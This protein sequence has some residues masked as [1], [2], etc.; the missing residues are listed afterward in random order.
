MYKTHSCGELTKQHIGLDVTLAGWVH[1]RRDHGGLIFL[2][3][4][5]RDGLTQVVC[6]SS[7]NSDAHANASRARNEFVLQVR[8]RVRERPEGLANP[9]LATGDIEVLAESVE[10]L[11]E[12]KTPPFYINE[13][14]DVEETLRLKYRYLDLRRERMQRNMILRHRVVKFIRDYLDA[15]GFIEIETPI[16]IKS[17]PE[18]AR[19]YLVPS[20]LHPGKF[21]AL[22]QSPQQLKQLLMVAGMER[23]F[24]IARCFRDEDQRADRQPEFT[25]LDLEMSFVDQEDILS[26]IEGLFIALIEAMR[27]PRCEGGMD[28]R[29]RILQT[30]FPRLTYAEAMER[31]GSDKPDLRFGMQL[32]DLSD[33]VAESAF[34]VFREAVLHG[35]QV[36]GILAPGAGAYTRKQLDEL[37]EMVKR[38]GAKGLIWIIPERDAVRSPAAKHLTPAETS[39]II[40]RMG[41]NEGDLILTIADKPEIVAEALGNLR[42]EMGRRLGLLDDDVL[43]FAWVLDFPLLEWSAEEGRWTAKHHPFTSAKDEDWPLLESE[44]AKVRA[45]AYDIVANGYEVGGGSIRIHRRDL[46]NRMFRALGITEEEMQAQFGHLLEAFEYG[47]PPHGGIAP[48][49][50][51]LVMLLAGEPNIREVIAFPKTQAAVDLMTSAPSPVS[52]RQL[53]DLHLKLALDGK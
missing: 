43:A 29:K 38:W 53:R 3:L 27:R 39:A 26:L 42:L 14:T 16:L 45:K 25:Q 21:Y 12:S 52:P 35:G 9:N 47:P 30:P 19:D 17:T 34:G 50:D 2:D 10:V 8:G 44:P 22:P 33:L 49:I 31:Y 46:Q 28:L 40:E 37:G 13:D 20:R 4:R 23:Y 41:A 5:D 24:Q 1:R 51:R 6:D 11:S 7:L 15:R 36:K 32:T 18:G 48:G